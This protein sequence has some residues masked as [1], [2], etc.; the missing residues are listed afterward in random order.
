MVSLHSTPTGLLSAFR[1]AAS[2]GDRPGAYASF[3]Y[4]RALVQRFRAA[5]PRARW[6]AEGCWFVPG[7]TAAKRVDAWMAQELASL[8]RYADDKGRDAY[9]FEPLT[10]DYLTVADDLV[11]RTPYSRTVVDQMRAIPWARWDPEARVW[12]V[13]F[14][15][16]DELRRRW[17]EI[18]AAARRNEPEARRRKLPRGPDP[19]AKRLQAER[20]RRRYPV[21]GDDLPPTGEPVATAFGV[22]VFETIEG[23]PVDREAAEAFTHV[24]DRPNRYVWARWRLPTFRELRAVKPMPAASDAEASE[25]GWWLP[26]SEALD[27]RLQQLRR[28]ERM[29]GMRQPERRPTVG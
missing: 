7:T 8:D 20:R 21:P 3:P 19:V 25:R 1:V 17:P 28:S 6:R 2:G 9:L 22:V 16:Y 26:D 12:R 23:A 15:S 24:G 11:V 14:R 18:E 13:P 29:R 5:F 10:S 27:A 4:D